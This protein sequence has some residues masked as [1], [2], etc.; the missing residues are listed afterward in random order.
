MSALACCYA[1]EDI[2]TILYN[3]TGCDQELPAS[4]FIGGAQ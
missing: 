2:R 3:V 1:S 4:A